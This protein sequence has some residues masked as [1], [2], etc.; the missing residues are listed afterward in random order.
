MIPIKKSYHTVRE[1]A[2]PTSSYVAGTVFSVDEQNYLGVLVK[3]TKGDETSV[4]VQIETRVNGVW[5]VQAAEGTP[6]SGE[7]AVDDAF[8]TYTATGNYWI[9]VSPIKADAVRVSVK[10]TGGTPTGT[11]GID[12]VTGWV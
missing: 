12:A 9:V 5:G 10:S 4:Q 6:S 2:E 8:R 11:V 7:I 3:Y 1:V